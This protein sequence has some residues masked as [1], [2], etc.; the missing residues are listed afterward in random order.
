MYFV[1]FISTGLKTIDILWLELEQHFYVD[2]C[3]LWNKGFACAFRNWP[4]IIKY[5]EIYFFGN[6]ILLKKT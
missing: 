1:C 2:Q 5:K 3:S 4:I 6:Y